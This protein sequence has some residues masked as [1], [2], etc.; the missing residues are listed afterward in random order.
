ML[1]KMQV[2][3]IQEKIAGL[4]RARAEI[5]SVRDAMVGSGAEPFG[6][7]TNRQQAVRDAYA[8]N[9]E[10]IDTELAALRDELAENESNA[11]QREVGY[12]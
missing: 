10:R 12:S 5:I 2:R 1:S 11:H 9:L 8:P 4:E 6:E 3:E 7:L